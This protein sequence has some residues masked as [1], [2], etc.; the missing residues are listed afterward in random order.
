MKFPSGDVATFVIVHLASE[1][2]ATGEYFD[3]PK[4]IRLL[5]PGFDLQDHPDF[6]P[7]W[8]RVEAVS[9]E[10]VRG[11]RSILGTAIQLPRA[12]EKARLASEIAAPNVVVVASESEAENRQRGDIRISRSRTPI[13]EPYGFGNIGNA[14]RRGIREEVEIEA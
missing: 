11:V 4:L 7:D 6:R 13:P 10:N 5:R 3:L 8:S 14:R 9:A 12:D 1:S 2:R